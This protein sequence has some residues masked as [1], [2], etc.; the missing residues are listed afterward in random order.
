MP[1]FVYIHSVA[2]A[3]VFSFFISMPILADNHIAANTEYNFSR[4]EI[5]RLL[6]N[7]IKNLK[8]IAEQSIVLEAIVRQN[9]L[10]T[11]LKEI[12]QLDAEWINTTGDAAF[13]KAVLTSEISRYLKTLVT[14]NNTVYSEIFLTDNQGALVAAYPATSDYWQGDEAKWIE[15]WNQGDGDIY[16]GKIVYDESSQTDAI[17]ISVPV[18]N[19]DEIIGVLVGG[20]RLTYLQSKY[21]HKLSTE[22]N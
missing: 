13:K 5:K 19:Y 8:D 17:Q 12:K 21:L 1:V 6:N 15:A 9:N 22:K 7:K 18:Y 3:L 16:I 2:A 20:I 11:T 14:T 4:Y 10:N